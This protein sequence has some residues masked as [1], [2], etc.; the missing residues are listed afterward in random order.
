MTQAEHVP[1]PWEAE[2]VIQGD[3]PTGVFDIIGVVDGEEVVVASEVQGEDARLII[4]APDLL[5][6]C[7]AAVELIDDETVGQRLIAAI[8]AA[9]TLEDPTQ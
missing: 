8:A 1:A 2:E 6:A 4:A 9:T 3:E 7:Q 5:E